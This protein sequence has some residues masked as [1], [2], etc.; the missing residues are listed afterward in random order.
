MSIINPFSQGVEIARYV[1]AM[2]GL[3]LDDATVTSIENT[4]N[5]S[6]NG[7]L[8]PLANSA[9][10]TDFGTATPASVATTVASNLGLTGTLLTQAEAY[11]Q[12]QLNAA[13]PGTQ[14]QTMLSMLNMFGGLTGDPVWGV[15]ATAWENKVSAAVS[16]GQNP[17]DY[18]N[19]SIA[20]FPS[21]G[22]GS[23][24]TLTTGL[25]S[26]PSFGAVAGNATFNAPQ[27][28]NLNTFNSGD[29]LTA[30][31]TGN[32]LNADLVNPGIAILAT[33][34]NIQTINI[35]SEQTATTSGNNNPNNSF[36]GTQINGLNMSGVTNWGDIN[37][38][39]DVAIENIQLPTAGSITDNVTFTMRNTQPGGVGGSGPNFSA[40]FDPQSLVRAN[41]QNTG[42][43]TVEIGGTAPA[44]SFNA[45]APL[46]NQPYAGVAINR[47]GTI[48][49]LFFSAADLAALKA[50]G[51]QAQFQTALSDAVAAYNTAH[52]TN[53][54]VTTNTN[55]YAFT[56]TDGQA[57]TANTYT[58]SEAGVV[59][60]A[61]PGIADATGNTSPG[62]L[63]AGVLPATNAFTATIGGTASS[64][65]TLITSEIILD[66][67]GQGGMPQDPQY[68]GSTE[69]PSGN[70]VIGSMAT[71]GGVQQFNVDVQ[72]GSWINS[73]DSTNNEL[74]VVNITSDA[75]LSPATGQYL[76]IG[77]ENGPAAG[78]M[79]GYQYQYNFVQTNG[80]TDVKTINAAAFNGSLM[81]GETIDTQA[82][83]KYLATATSPVNFSITLGDN[84]AGVT[85]PHSGN[86]F[87]SVNLSIDP[88][89]LASGNFVE[90]INGGTGNDY[91]YVTA[92]SLATDNTGW[93][94]SQSNLG[95]VTI[96]AGQGN[97]MVDVYGSVT[98]AISG[99][100]G[101][102]TYY[103][104]NSGAKSVW[105]S[106]AG[107]PGTTTNITAP[108]AA[109]NTA[110]TPATAAIAQTDTVTWTSAVIAGSETIDGITATLTGATSAAAIA[111]AVAAGNGT[112]GGITVSGEGGANG[113]TSGAASGSTTLLTYGTAGGPVI[114]AAAGSTGV[115]NSAPTEV[116]VQPPVNAIAAATQVDIVTW[117]GFN[118]FAGTEV[119]SIGGVTVT[120]TTGAAFT[121][122]QVAA[123]AAGTVTAGLTVTN[124]GTWAVS[125]PLAGATTFT[126]NATDASVSIGTGTASETHT[127]TNTTVSM[128]VYGNYTTSAA[129]LGATPHTF[130]G[131]NE[132]VTVRYDGYSVTQAIVP[133]AGTGSTTYT[134][135]DINNAILK[136]VNG[137]SVL[138]QVLHVTEASSGT[139]LIFNS[140][141]DGGQ[142]TP[143]ITFAAPTAALTAAQIAA[144][145]AYTGVASGTYTAAQAAADVV[146]LAN[147]SGVLGAN[148]AG[149]AVIAPSAVITTAAAAL[150]AQVDTVTWGALG[151]GGVETING[152]TVSTSGAASSTQIAADV[153]SGNGF[154]AGITV[155]GEGGPTGWG[156]GVA[157]GSTT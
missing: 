7:S 32:V 20:A 73:L 106:N 9:Y 117:A 93:A 60:G 22:V 50:G 30:T 8:A 64:V 71:S 72:R 152:I 12:A 44:G 31:G 91:I 131:I 69:G 124:S 123:A 135:A 94:V 21:T 88:T 29:V 82:Y 57:R 48:I 28:G 33:T 80:L 134:T 55:A 112:T 137:N 101:N 92:S 83:A 78:N 18:S 59:I 79:T 6:A 17:T 103:V 113:W 156:L 19:G 51:T 11:I 102:D 67:V 37:S 68:S 26:G 63:A 90:T 148:G 47:A 41:A 5:T 34:T 128:D 14:G 87:N 62:W 109:V 24:F 142:S 86:S 84:T 1:G 25:S 120:D 54:V 52:G 153:A 65:N 107:V 119:Q 146:A 38:R 96:N 143:T 111:A 56:S 151:A 53:M 74:Q 36:T 23:T 81:I 115:G 40:Y 75:T 43:V 85:I 77:A 66:N 35:T 150:V 10:A 70:V 136:A 126:A 133:A 130:T 154:Y 147:E 132:T 138:D 39:D 98:A 157:S 114:A 99:G 139:S 108:T 145:D 46:L 141:V 127:S 2:Y 76:F 61:G 149:M 49:D 125:A 155:A 140:L 15:A 45:A 122:T 129:Q 95:N 144:G 3:V 116:L 89:V 118:A 16:Y 121:A 100:T 13:A 42:T 27:V 97:N 104:D 105:V 58:I 4:A 110:G